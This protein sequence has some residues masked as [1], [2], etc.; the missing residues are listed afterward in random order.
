MVKSSFSWVVACGGLIAALTLGSGGLACN[1]LYGLDGYQPVD[2]GT[3]EAPEGMD[4]RGEA[5]DSSDTST[6]SSCV[7]GGPGMTNCG[8]DASQSCCESLTVES[9][10][11]FR[12]YDPVGAD[13][14]APT[15]EADGGP[16]DEGD[17]ATVSEFRLD[18]YLVTVGRFRQFVNAVIPSDGGPG[19]IP[20][21]GSGKHTYLNQGDGL[22]NSASPGTFEPG[23]LASDKFNIA[24]TDSN[25][26]PT[27]NPNFTTWTATPGANEHL[28]INCVNWYEAY[29]F[30][31]W[32][33]AFLPSEAEWEY[34]AAGGSQQRLY[35]WGAEP[36][37]SQNQYAIYGCHYPE[38]SSMCESSPGVPAVEPAPVGDSP[39]GRSRWGQVDM[40]G[41]VF[42]WTLDVYN[43]T[44]IDPCLNCA[45]LSASGPQ[46]VLRGS[47]FALLDTA[48]LV[49]SFRYEADPTDRRNG[50]GF[51]C[52]RAPSE[53]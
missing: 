41:E 48:Y 43:T 2:G 5:T 19:W 42:E 6:P 18:K 27:C 15:L 3:A 23:W 34:A 44:Y 31:I 14:G 26:G 8:A 21:S 13:G 33:G 12:T 50:V 53:Q 22:S 49:S 51:R 20:P 11:Y 10:T 52:A 25:L 37:G 9:G 38:G 39:A 24:P 29:A 35:P 46:Q 47:D 32:D 45:Y 7:P 1:A 36:P 17:P 4:A 28:P 40:A 16:S 30:C